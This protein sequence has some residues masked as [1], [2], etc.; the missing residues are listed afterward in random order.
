[1]PTA[2]AKKLYLNQPST[3]IVTLY[4]VPASTTTIVKSI[5]ITNTTAIDAKIDLYFVPSGGTPAAANKM[6]SQIT[7]PANGAY[8]EDC[9]DVLS[10][11]DSIQSAQVTSGALTVHISGVEV[12]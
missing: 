6:I 1:M 9:T 8:R 2:T 12:V 5:K 7:V 11:G 4:I 10:A 3:S